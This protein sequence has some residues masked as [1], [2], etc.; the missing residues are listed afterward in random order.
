MSYTNNF[1]TTGGTHDIILA[2][3][4]N[5]LAVTVTNGSDTAMRVS[6]DANATS[7]TGDLL[8]AGASTTLRNL[9]GRKVTVYCAAGSKAGSFREDI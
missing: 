7:S 5:F 9:C 2:G 6:V 1:T 8:A 3:G 4:H